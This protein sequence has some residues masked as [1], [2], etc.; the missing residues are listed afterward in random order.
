MVDASFATSGNLV[1]TVDGGWREVQLA[2]EQDYRSPRRPESHPPGHVDVDALGKSSCLSGGSYVIILHGDTCILTSS[3]DLNAL[4]WAIEGDGIG[5]WWFISLDLPHEAQW[6][7]VVVAFLSLFSYSIVFRAPCTAWHT[8]TQFSLLQE[9]YC[10]NQYNQ[11]YGSTVLPKCL[12]Q[13]LPLCLLQSQWP[14]CCVEGTVP[15][16]RDY[17]S[18]P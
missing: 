2:V 9:G 4:I 7:D 1:N 17:L 5:Y 10:F 14:I 18:A 6:L 16:S 13:A 12:I 15:S 3:C 11:Q 8:V